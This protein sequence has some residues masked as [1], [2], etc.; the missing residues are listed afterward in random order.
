MISYDDEIWSSRA[1]GQPV[2][3]QEMSSRG[4]RR[5][6]LSS[7]GA[8]V[9]VMLA[10]CSPISRIGVTLAPSQ[11]IEVVLVDCGPAAPW[12]ITSV[13]LLRAGPDPLE[14]RR[15]ETVLW[16]MVSPEPR[17]AARFTVGKVGSGFTE[18][19]MFDGSLSS[20]TEVVAIVDDAGGTQEA[21][22]FRPRDLGPG[23]VFYGGEQL[24]PASFEREAQRGCPSNSL[25]TIGILF[26]LLLGSGLVLWVVLS[27]T[28]R[29]EPRH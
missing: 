15:G 28:R 24:S 8:G 22:Y 10:S 17:N 4:G 20:D 7:L 27:A 21:A 25:R 18:T 3:G 14:P 5:C 23:S 9:V 13:A 12:A 16:R 1:S 26:L 11:A 29:R 2:E 6:A 19:K